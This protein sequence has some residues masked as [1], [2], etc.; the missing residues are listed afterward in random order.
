MSF[1]GRKS[2]LLPVALALPLLALSH[3]P[4][5]P[6]ATVPRAGTPT[7]TAAPDPASL[8]RERFLPARELRPGQRAICRTVFQGRTVEDFELEIVGVL[9]GGRAEGDMILARA[10]SDRLKHDGIAA[11]MSGSP[12][13][14]DGKLIGALAFSWP[15][16][17]DP[18]CGI[19]PIAEMLDV[20]AHPAASP[21]G[22]FEDSSAWT[23]PEVE[24]TRTSADPRAATG[25]AWTRI[26]APLVVGGLSEPA[27][28]LLAPFAEEHG[29]MMVQ[30]GA[31]GSST[32]ATATAAER[33][34]LVPGAAISVDL[35]RG[36]ANISG[37]GTLTYRDRERVIAFGHPFF[38][39]GDVEYPLSLADITTIIAS[40]LSS[41]KV[42]TPAE[43]LGVITQ[44]RRAGIAGHLGGTPAR[45]LPLTVKVHGL[46]IE[47]TYRFEVLRHRLLAPQLTQVAAFSALTARGSVVPEATWRY[48]ATLS[49]KGR[50][51]IVLEDVAT[52]AGIASANTL[53]G[54]LTLLLNN[55]F[56]PWIADSLSLDLTLASGLSRTT[57]WSATAEP[58]FVKPGGTV[59]VEAELKDLR[60]SVSTVPFELV[61]PANQPEGRLVLAIGGGP[62]LDRQELPRLPGRHRA[63]SLDQLV[64]RLE[65]RRRADHVYATLY[66]PGI[67]ATLDGEP[68]P[69]LPSFAQ[70]LIAS[71]R[72]TRPTE[73]WGR[74]DRVAEAKHTVGAPVAGVVTITLEVRRRPTA[75]GV[76]N[77]REARPG[78][79]F[80][81]LD[82]DDED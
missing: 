4:K 76:A 30:G 25:N 36:D 58:K 23:A 50:P 57:V 35:L 46:G 27:R 60:G 42:G 33:E 80:R 28:A 15:F 56:G 69:E 65:D 19:T 49:A 45:M 67:E 54:P 75:S 34:A 39:T 71:D 64:E 6:A 59:R 72:A 43:K 79:V 14:V 55:P 38:Q 1:R 53:G 77:G 3:V 74:L 37:I 12:V 29:F 31:G 41:F 73:P 17:R 51:P 24:P 44:D 63:S 20:L 70:R 18:L 47:E 81:A 10:T 78:G 9:P 16:S 82:S 61:V 13:Y 32:T 48:R 21:V 52:G 62:D 7:V 11:G 22:A 26:R 8:D 66:G 40:D 2:A 5:A 68:Y